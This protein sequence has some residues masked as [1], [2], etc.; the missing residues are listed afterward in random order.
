MSLTVSFIR[1][2]LPASA[3]RSTAPCARS[4]AAIASAKGSAAPSGIRS[5]PLFQTAIPLRMFSS[6][7]AWMP[8]MPTSLCAFASA[9]SFSTESTPARS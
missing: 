8:G 7:L 2:R 3:I 4:D 6:V 5:C 1:R 9:S